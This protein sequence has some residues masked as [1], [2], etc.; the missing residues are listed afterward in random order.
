[1]TRVAS[2]TNSTAI[3]EPSWLVTARSLV[4]TKEI[5]GAR[6]NNLIVAWLKAV[7]RAIQDDETAW[8]AAFTD[9]CLRVN[10]FATPV[11]LA[12][13]AVASSKHFIRLSGPAVGAVAAMH[14]GDPND[15][16]GHTGFVVA[17]D[18][19]RQRYALLGGNQNN[20]V[21]ISW[22]PF[23]RFEGRN[24][25]FFWPV[26]GPTPNRV[27]PTGTAPTTGQATVA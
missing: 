9:H 20:E 19:K 13:R 17:V 24:T 11:S 23:S 4:G 25:G 16:R 3:P 2:N 7:N 14:R 18:N 21:N 1:M 5:P 8:C 10:G 27:L 22:F 15:W 12:A 26:G 6:H